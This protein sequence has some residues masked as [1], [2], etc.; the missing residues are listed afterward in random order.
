MYAEALEVILRGMTCTELSFEGT[1]YRYTAVPMEL[2]PL[3]RPH[4]ALWYG[5]GRPDA[6]PWAAERRVNVV[7]NLG[8][9]GMRS[10]SATAPNGRRW[11]IGPMNCR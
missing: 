11:V 4:P 1:Y 6:V 5:I 10:P 3:Q 9:K 8:G 2:A 7:A